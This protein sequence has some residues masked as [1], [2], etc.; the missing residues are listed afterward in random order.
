MAANNIFQTQS[1]YF[2]RAFFC[3]RG[4]LIPQRIRSHVR[5]KS[6][7][8]PPS[9][10]KQEL[11]AQQ[12]HLLAALFLSLYA[13]AQAPW[14]PGAA[15]GNNNQA[16]SG[17]RPGGGG[18]Q[19]SGNGAPW[20][21]NPWAPGNGGQ[22]PGGGGGGNNNG[23]QAPWRASGNQGPFQWPPRQTSG[24]GGGPW[25]WPPGTQQQGGGRQTP[26]QT[27]QQTVV[28]T[29][30]VTVTITRPSPAAG[31]VGGGD[32]TPWAPGAS[33]TKPAAT[34]PAA[35]GGGGESA[36]SQPSAW[37]PPRQPFGPTSTATG[38]QTIPTTTTEAPR[39]PVPFMTLC[40][41]AQYV[42]DDV[43]NALV[44]GCWYKNKTQT[45]GGY[46]K[47][48]ANAEKI[49][50]GDVVAPWYEFPL[51]SSAAYVGGEFFPSGFKMQRLTA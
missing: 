32:Q 31:N 5:H 22:R 51:I 30:T 45:K 24:F 38:P 34:A 11:T 13:D 15:G 44:A 8:P 39:E 6:T 42:E 1:F 33:T 37:G 35:G 9:P 49:N 48:F 41:P 17:Q 36:W 47:V 25:G 40:G 26:Q 10:F 19:W 2:R 27:P 20:Q 50:F 18:G 28:V 3:V 29:P 46:P 14:G 21:G 12:P 4:S 43:S 23:E 16:G 7:P